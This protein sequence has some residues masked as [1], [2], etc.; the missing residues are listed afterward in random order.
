MADG[1]IIP[2]GTSV[3]QNPQGSILNNSNPQNPALTVVLFAFDKN[4][5]KTKT[6][7]TWEWVCIDLTALKTLN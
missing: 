5:A 2:C 1:P 4:I 6:L 3:P 7:H